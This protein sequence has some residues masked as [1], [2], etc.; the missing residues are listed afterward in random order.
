M[1]RKLWLVPVMLGLL[2]TVVNLFYLPKMPNPMVIHFGSDGQPNG[3]AHP[4]VGLLGLDLLGWVIIVMIM[5]L[6]RATLHGAIHA[7]DSNRSNRSNPRNPITAAWVAYGVSIV[8]WLIFLSVDL[9]LI[10]YNLK[11]T[12]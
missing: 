12:I 5:L 11:W 3:W 9:S 7:H 8:L 6:T 4:V 1:N 10:H 2:A